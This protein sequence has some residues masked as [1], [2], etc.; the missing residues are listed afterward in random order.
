MTSK[1]WQLETSRSQAGDPVGLSA[2]VRR[3]A[4]GRRK[5]RTSVSGL[6][7]R[8]RS[9]GTSRPA[10][11]ARCYRANSCAPTGDVQHQ[12]P[13][14]L[15]GSK[16]G[17]RLGSKLQ[18]LEGWRRIVRRWLNHTG[19][20]EDDL[21]DKSITIDAGNEGAPFATGDNDLTSTIWV[22][23]KRSACTGNGPAWTACGRP[24]LPLSPL[25]RRGIDLDMTR[26]GSL[27][28]C[29]SLLV[30]SQCCPRATER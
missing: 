3:S 11:T 22:R 26:W 28:S 7:L 9:G 21:R 13:R 8:S 14:G 23:L 1:R 4:G 20:A 6:D 10:H 16:N 12:R 5:Y 25:D 27:M 19:I 24:E 17:L 30:P 18:A 2:C 15:P 29:E